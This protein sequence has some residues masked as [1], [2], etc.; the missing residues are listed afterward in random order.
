MVDLARKDPT[1]KRT[2]EIARG[3]GSLT[4]H[5]GWQYLYELTQAAEKRFLSRL[6]KRL[7]SGVVVDQREIDFQRGYIRGALDTIQRPAEAIADLEKAARG[8][9]VKAAL[10]LTTETEGIPYE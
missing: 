3:L 9:W 2:A 1:W 6:A 4:E 10:E 5:E 8:A 7:F